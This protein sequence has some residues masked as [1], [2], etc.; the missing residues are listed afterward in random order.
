MQARLP[1]MVH[2]DMTR[3][4]MNVD[5]VLSR[6]HALMRYMHNSG[7]MRGENVESRF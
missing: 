6:C 4:R 5:R 7:A 2:A 3:T 1:V